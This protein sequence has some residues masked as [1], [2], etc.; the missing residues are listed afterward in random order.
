VIRVSASVEVL[1]PVSTFPHA[2]AF[3]VIW[4]WIPCRFVYNVHLIATL[5]LDALSAAAAA[6]AIV[7]LG[8]RAGDTRHGVWRTTF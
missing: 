6:I 4:F 7:R 3:G 2:L 8:H 1:W 5:Q